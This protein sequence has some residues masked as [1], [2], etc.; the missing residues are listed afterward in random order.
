[1]VLKPFGHP[2]DYLSPRQLTGGFRDGA[3]LVRNGS[4][5]RIDD[6]EL[7]LLGINIRRPV[8]LLTRGAVRIDNHF[9]IEQATTRGAC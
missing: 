1:V 2:N 6:H 4:D 5:I 7:K 8:L 9:G 3:R